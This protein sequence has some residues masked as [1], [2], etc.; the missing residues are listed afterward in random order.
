MKRVNPK[1][2]ISSLSSVFLHRTATLL[3]VSSW[4]VCWKTWAWKRITSSTWP[5]GFGTERSLRFNEQLHF[6]PLTYIL[7]SWIWTT[8]DWVAR[9]D[10]M[11]SMFLFNVL[12]F[13]GKEGESSENLRQNRDYKRYR[14]K[15]VI[16]FFKN[17]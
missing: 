9:L 5:R 6:L 15:R 14:N 8:A 16:F 13:K 11:F 2:L 10:Q 1:A 17:Q 7:S 12:L 3:C 4:I